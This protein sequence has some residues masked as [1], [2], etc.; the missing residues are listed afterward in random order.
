MVKEGGGAVQQKHTFPDKFCVEV[1]VTVLQYDPNAIKNEIW[2]FGFKMVAE[3]PFEINFLK[4]I[5]P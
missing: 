1:Y 5:F 2:S 4:G 3:K